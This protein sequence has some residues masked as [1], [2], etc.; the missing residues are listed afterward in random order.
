MSHDPLFGL[1][2]LIADRPGPQ[3]ESEE[4]AVRIVPQSATRSWVS[5]ERLSSP[6]VPPRG[7]D[8]AKE[9]RHRTTSA[10]DAHHGRIPT[11]LSP[12]SG[13]RAGYVAGDS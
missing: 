1:A 9:L 11:R 12:D 3:L 10:C 2:R 4:R 8:Q 5:H 6:R 13:E 7:A